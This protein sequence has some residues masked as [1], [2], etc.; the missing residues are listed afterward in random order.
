MTRLGGRGAATLGNTASYKREEAC[1]SKDGRCRIFFHAKARHQMAA[2]KMPRKKVL[3]RLVQSV[4]LVSAK[5]GRGCRECLT[6]VLASPIFFGT[7]A[8]CFACEGVATFDL[9][10]KAA[11]NFLREILGSFHSEKPS[12]WIPLFGRITT[13]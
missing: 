9:G 10:F 6:L 12:K 3:V 1:N 11:A 7:V 8:F 13:T 5:F 4:Q 2:F